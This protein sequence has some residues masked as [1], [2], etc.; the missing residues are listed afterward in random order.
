MRPAGTVAELATALVGWFGRIWPDE[1]RAA[2]AAGAV[3]RL[4]GGDTRPVT[5]ETCAA[6]TGT[7]QEFSRHFLLAHDPGSP[8][9][10]DPDPPGWEP[11]DPDAVRAR[12]AF[13]SRVER[14]P[15]DVA[16]V[17]L[18]GLDPVHLAAPYL[19]AAFAL[20]GTARGVVLDLTGNGGGDPATLTLVLDWVVGPVP[21]HVSDVHGRDRVRQWWTPGRP[22]ATA[23]PP[24]TP[25]AVVTGARTFSSG[26][27]LAYHL[28]HL[29]GAVVVGETTRGAADHVTPVRVTP[30][31]TAFLPEAVVVDATTGTNWEGTGVLP[32]VAC[33]EAGA[34]ARAV[35]E[36]QARREGR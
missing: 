25:L 24:G 12:A 6:V 21:A 32:D 20:A 22:A 13:V 26:E 35:A 34:L 5:A 14:L 1:R 17:A 19:A 31:V 4:H 11:P 33:P 23:L 10:P 27:A 15:G 8:R 16:V 18:D 3:R 2:A 9:A 30:T 7:V 29:C 36:V 28:R